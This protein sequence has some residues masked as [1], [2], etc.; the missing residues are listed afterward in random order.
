MNINSDYSEDQSINA[1]EAMEMS[2]GW[3]FDNLIKPN[4]ADMDEE[5]LLMLAI[6]GSTFKEMASRANAWDALQQNRDDF[7]RN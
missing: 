3:I 6:I 5:S 4:E 1:E 2:M 7:S